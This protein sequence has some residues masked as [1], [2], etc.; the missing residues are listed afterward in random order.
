MTVRHGRRKY[1]QF[2][3]EAGTLPLLP[4]YTISNLMTGKKKKKPSLTQTEK[5]DKVKQ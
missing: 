1:F 3:V 2:M 5:V 4:E